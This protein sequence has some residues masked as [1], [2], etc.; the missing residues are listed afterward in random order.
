[1]TAKVTLTPALSL[2]LAKTGACVGQ[3]QGLR[4]EKDIVTL[5]IITI[6]VAN[7]PASNTAPQGLTLLPVPR[8][9]SR[10]VSRAERGRA[11]R[12]KATN[13]AVQCAQRHDLQ[14]KSNRGRAGEGGKSELVIEASLAL[15]CEA[16]NQVMGL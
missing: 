10:G 12:R 13:Y 5:H 14:S 11:A 4:I 6:G 3:P 2:L 15:R 8:T 1:M 9:P 7:R 16:G